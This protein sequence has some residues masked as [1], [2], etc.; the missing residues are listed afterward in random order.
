MSKK[1]D[2]VLKITNVILSII[3]IGLFFITADIKFGIGSLW[4]LIV[5]INWEKLDAFKSNN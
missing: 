4:C 1:I 2:V 3:L 5:Y